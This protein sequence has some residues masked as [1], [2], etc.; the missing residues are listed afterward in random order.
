[1]KLKV[2]AHS[3]NLISDGFTIRGVCDAQYRN[4]RNTKTSSSLKHLTACIARDRKV[5]QMIS[6]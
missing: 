6:K 5:M 1:M 4:I 2:L 3:Q